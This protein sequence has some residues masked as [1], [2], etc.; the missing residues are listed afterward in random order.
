MNKHTPW[1]VNKYGD[2]VAQEDIVVAEKPHGVSRE[3]DTNA[4][5]I[6]AAPELLEALEK[7]AE[8]TFPMGADGFET[9]QNLCHIARAALAKVQG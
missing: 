9:W 3:W 4:R 7:I 5:L 8:S 6:A 1:H 2:C